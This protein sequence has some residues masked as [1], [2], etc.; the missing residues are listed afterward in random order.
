MKETIIEIIER[1]DD[2]T[3][4][5]YSREICK[6]CE[7]GEPVKKLGRW[8]HLKRLG[9]AWGRIYHSVCAGNEIRLE[10]DGEAFGVRRGIW[11][12]IS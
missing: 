1:I 11:Y 5:E 12:A 9:D 10:R 7:K 6:D 3:I 4:A 2:A 8:V